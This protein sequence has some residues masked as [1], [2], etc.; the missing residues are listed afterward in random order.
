MGVPGRLAVED[1]GGL[2]S[3]LSGK[4]FFSGKASTSSIDE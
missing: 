2:K 4:S 3:T 1:F